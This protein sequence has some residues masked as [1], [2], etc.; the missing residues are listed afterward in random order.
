[1]EV[2]WFNQEPPLK[3]LA[4]ISLYLNAVFI[5]CCREVMVITELQGGQTV[6]TCG[7][8]AGRTGRTLT[9]R[10]GD[11]APDSG[12]S[13]KIPNLLRLDFSL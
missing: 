11:R 10:P 8:A 9:R 4:L 5:A 3:Y 7:E 12:S 13:G 1:M 2:K 6:G